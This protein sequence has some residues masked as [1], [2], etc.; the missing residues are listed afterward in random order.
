M[1]QRLVLFS[2]L[3]AFLTPA[4]QD[5]N[6]EELRGTVIKE[7]RTFEEVDVSSEADILFVI[8]NSGSMAGEQRQ[9]AESFRVLTEG[10]E[11]KFGDEYRIAIVTTGMESQACPACSPDISGS[12]INPTGENGRFQD[13]ICRNVGTDSSPEYV[14]D[15]PVESCRVVDIEDTHCFYDAAAQEGTLFV[16]T[17]G[18]GYE[19]GFAP[20]K[21]ALGQLT[22]SY[23]KD[24]LREDAALAVVI[25]SA[26]DDCG[27]VGDVD[28]FT[29]DMGNICY[30][31]AKGVGPRGETVH[32][33]DPQQRKYELTPV[34]EY[35]RFLI[36][37]VKGGRKGKVKFAAVVGVKDMADPS[38]TTIEYEMG[39]NDRWEVTDACRTPNCT[40]IYCHAEPSTRYIKMAQMF[41]LGDNGFLD[42]I[43]Q[44]DFAE[45]LEKIVKFIP[46]TRAFKL[47]EPPLDPA[48]AAILIDG[49]EI[50]HYTCSIKGRLEV[51][52]GEGD[53]CPQGSECVRT[54]VFCD[55]AD[56]DPHP[57]CLC[58]ADDDRPYPECEPLDFTK[59]EGGVIVFANHYDPCK[60]ID[61]GTIHIEFV[62]VIP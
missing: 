3:L 5:Y 32:P 46:C 36:D 11:K 24:F 47:K 21:K 13:R 43:C 55:P 30:F 15:N 31:A 6:Y 8:D 50:P 25:I 51:C 10:L 17:D 22:S 35:Y 16:G 59:A 54:Y 49:E 28:E 7:I 1:T 58:D 56:P 45:T 9:L 57:E 12:C 61:E 2:C 23:N 62:Y 53:S 26:A 4:C 29:Y 39:A 14:C 19:R 60:L 44:D 52:E 34:E 41:G 42:T 38:T 33:D 20:L 48:L 18:C 40:G 27:E 37:D